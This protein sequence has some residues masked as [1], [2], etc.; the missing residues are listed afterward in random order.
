[1]RKRKGTKKKRAPEPRRVS[2]NVAEAK[3]RAAAAVLIADG[4]LDECVSDPVLDAAGIDFVLHK[5]MRS[6]EGKR[7]HQRVSLHLQIKQTKQ[8]AG[9]HR[10]RYPT[11]PVLVIQSTRAD[12][13][14][15]AT[16]MWELFCAHFKD[17]IYGEYLKTESGN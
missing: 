15:I 14:S 2:E 7:K 12:I 11:I 17:G 13:Q 8:A 6:V 16:E 4:R 9:E 5:H 1:M 3:C 10:E